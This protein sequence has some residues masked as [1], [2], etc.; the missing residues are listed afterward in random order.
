MTQNRRIPVG[1]SFSSLCKRAGGSALAD[2][3]GLTAPDLV[4]LT[5]YKAGKGTLFGV[6]NSFS[7]SHSFHQSPLV[8]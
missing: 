4:K 3:S 1:M 2:K 6:K 5:A 8:A 7:F